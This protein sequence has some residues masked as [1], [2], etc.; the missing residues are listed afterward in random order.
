MIRTNETALLKWDK[1][2][3]VWCFKGCCFVCEA[4]YNRVSNAKV[5][6]VIFKH[7]RI[8]V[9]A[10]QLYPVVVAGM[11]REDSYT[12]TNYFSL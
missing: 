10:A 8:I 5:F 7:A 11:I 3:G 4:F 9:T 12:N 2:G 6:Y 1:N